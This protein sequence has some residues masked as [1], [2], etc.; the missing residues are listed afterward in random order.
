MMSRR[1][2]NKK[3]TNEIEREKT[4]KF[5]KKLSLILLIIVII[6]ILI[7]LYMRFLGTSFIKTEEKYL[8]DNIPH[9]FNGL[10]VL[11][12]S[13]LM[14]GSTINDSDLEKISNEVKMINPDIIF[15]TGDLIGNNYNLIKKDNIESFLTN[16]SAPYG[17]YA[18]KGELDNEDYE[19]L[20]DKCGFEI[21]INNTKE[22]F[23]KTVDKII[24]K[25]LDSNNI[26][27]VDNTDSY[28]IC[29]IHNFDYFDKFNTNC[30][31]TF[32]GHNL[33]GEIRIPFTKGILGNNKYKG[34]YYVFGNNEIFIYS[35]L[36]SKHKL[37]LFNHPEI[38]VYRIYEKGI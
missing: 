8:Y 6:I 13:D 5:S 12:I 34:N 14:Y 19:I 35:G 38:N 32:A 33:G 25:G 23:N 24:I 3:I 2:L 10:K 31:V 37:R 4:I 9:S 28:T 26:E 21:L 18:I 20:L 27:S 7:F 30:D 11:Q 1:E 15:F 16:L 17:K 29:L 22:I 36:G